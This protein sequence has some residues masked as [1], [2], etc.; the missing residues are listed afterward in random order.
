MQAV[1]NY[2]RDKST[3]FF[4]FCHLIEGNYLSNNIII[5]Y[6]SKTLYAIKL[7]L[8]KLEYFNIIEENHE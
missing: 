5:K 3:L 4:Y 8:T 7:L 2:K 6:Y 1:L